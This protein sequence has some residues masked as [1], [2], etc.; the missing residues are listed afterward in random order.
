[1]TTD[2][3]V[4]QR[5][6]TLY[7]TMSYPAVTMG[8]L[9]LP[10]I[11][12]VE[13]VRHTRP[14][15]EF[16][17]VSE[18]DSAEETEAGQPTG[19]EETLSETAEETTPE[20]EME[21]EDL[22]REIEYESAT[23]DEAA[24]TVTEPTGA[25]TP[26]EAGEAEEFD[27]TTAVYAPPEPNP[28]LQIRVDRE[29]FDKRAEEVL[30]LEGTELE[31]AVVGGEIVVRF[32]L[33]EIPTE[34]PVAYNFQVRTAAGRLRSPK[35]NIASFVPLPPPPPPSS[36]TLEPSA[37]GV[38]ISWL[39]PSDVVPKEDEFAQIEVGEE[40]DETEE[41]ETEKDETE[42]PVDDDLQMPAT[43][44]LSEPG[45]EPM[46]I[47]G[48]NVYRRLRNATL[49][50]PQPLASVS[51]DETEFL[52]RSAQYGSS[53]AYTVITLRMRRPRV[54][55]ELAEEIEV[56]YRDEF[57]PQA[58]SGLVVLA[59][60]GRTRLVWEASPESDVVGY[61]VFVR[62]GEAA[63]EPL[64]PDPI[65]ANEFIHRDTT[66]GVTYTYRVVA[67]DAAGNESEPSREATTRAP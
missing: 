59:E 65:A 39:A 45:E 12:R 7:V 6:R 15:P 11:D 67:V 19:E 36:V 21:I 26:D 51:P 8:G 32:P 27:Q 61:L 44:D 46:E 31:S 63:Y 1:M 20:G 2:L 25:E 50:P 22:E 24:P 43:Q 29:E 48:Y 13:Y 4:F 5:G 9:A 10:G 40:E 23:S 16:V 35:S 14:A 41:D 42:P 47:E 53:Y 64:T 54:E 60:A 52:D 62:R 17:E 3:S 66:S 58:P 55:S 34:P 30:V 57:P 33:E 56:R 49:Y 18:Q 28:Y 38:E 37:A